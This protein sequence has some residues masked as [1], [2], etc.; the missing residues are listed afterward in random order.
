MVPLT[1][2]FLAWCLL[3]KHACMQSV[4]SMLRKLLRPFPPPSAPQRRECQQRAPAWGRWLALAGATTRLFAGANA[5]AS[6]A[7]NGGRGGDAAKPQ[8]E[9]S[10]APRRPPAWRTCCSCRRCSGPSPPYGRAPAG[11]GGGRPLATA[12]PSRHGK[13]RE[14]AS[15]SP[16]QAHLQAR[17]V[18]PSSDLAPARRPPTACTPGRRPTTRR[19]RVVPSVVQRPGCCASAAGQSVVSWSLPSP[20]HPPGD[21]PAL[22]PLPRFQSPSPPAPKATR[23]PGPAP[24]P[25]PAMLTPAP[26]LLPQLAAPPHAI[27][28]PALF[29]SNGVPRT[30]RLPAACSPPTAIWCKRGVRTEREGRGPHWQG[31]GGTQELQRIEGAREGPPQPDEGHKGRYYMPIRTK[32]GLWKGFAV[33]GLC[34]GCLR[35]LGEPLCSGLA[36]GGGTAAVCSARIHALAAVVATL[37]KNSTRQ[38]PPQIPLI[39][40]LHPFWGHWVSRSHLHR[41]QWSAIREELRSTP[42]G[43]RHS[44]MTPRRRSCGRC[45]DPE[46]PWRKSPGA[47]DRALRGSG[48]ACSAHMRAAAAASCPD[49]AGAVDQCSPLTGGVLLQRQQP[50]QG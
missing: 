5:I 22:C 3:L 9:Q 46:P 41:A 17:A 18:W 29:P 1:D 36:V 42:P 11:H 39:H 40:Y 4:P 12:L 32:T 2:S 24:G 34:A 48:D 23:E 43:W 14:H 44:A 7:A 47:L 28:A 49:R 6:Q 33:Q 10:C 27:C 21:L 50:A 35:R 19:P 8:T 30:T 37:Y 16:A 45:G 13:P 20:C 38:Q 15:P 26:P 31:S 25:S